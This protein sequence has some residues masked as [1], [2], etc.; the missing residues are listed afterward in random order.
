VYFACPVKFFE[1]DSI[2]YLT[3]VPFCLPCGMRSLFL[4]GGYI[5]AE[6]MEKVE[7][8]GGSE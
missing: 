5:K 8:S 6:K 4:W 2:A 7:K 3:G 1:K